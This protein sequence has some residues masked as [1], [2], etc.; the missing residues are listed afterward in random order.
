VSLHRIIKCTLVGPYFLKWQVFWLLKFSSFTYKNGS[1]KFDPKYTIKTNAFYDLR[2]REGY[3]L[4]LSCHKT[5]NYLPLICICTIMKQVSGLSQ[6][7][8][9]LQASWTLLGLS[10]KGRVEV[11][12]INII[13]T[14]QPIFIILWWLFVFVKIINMIVCVKF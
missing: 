3:T 10:L 2:L 7:L 5:W 12:E 9:K 14:S 1:I 13:T 4:H 8:I 11:L 6:V